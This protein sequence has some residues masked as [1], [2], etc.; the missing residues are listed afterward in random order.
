MWATRQVDWGCERMREH[1]WGTCLKGSCWFYS[2]AKRVLRLGVPCTKFLVCGSLWNHQ[3]DEACRPDELLGCNMTSTKWPMQEKL[4][5]WSCREL[6]R[7]HSQVSWEAKGEERGARQNGNDE[8]GR[9]SM[10]R[11]DKSDMTSS[12]TMHVQYSIPSFAVC[13]YHQP[14]EAARGSFPLSCSPP[15]VEMQLCNVYSICLL[16]VWSMKE[17]TNQWHCRDGWVTRT[18]ERTTMCKLIGLEFL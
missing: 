6:E 2:L 8:Q 11:R 10:E 1:T 17:C 9:P 4:P 14:K 7:I 16:L 18:L 5:T 13:F 12:A 3:G 15:T